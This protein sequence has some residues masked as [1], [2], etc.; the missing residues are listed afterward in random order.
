MRPT[1]A[2]CRGVGEAVRHDVASIDGQGQTS[3]YV[4]GCRSCHAC[5]GGTMMKTTA[6]LQ[7]ILASLMA[8]MLGAVPV[9]AQQI[10]GV[11]GSPDATETIDGRY[12]PPP[13]APFGG[14]IN[15]NAYQSKPY[16]PARIVPPKDAPNVL[17]IM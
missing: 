6:V 10:T 12:L 11:P 17:L 14:E 2:Q 15:L 8:V 13:P 9:M 16:W 7:T 5:T 1:E 4:R 3:G